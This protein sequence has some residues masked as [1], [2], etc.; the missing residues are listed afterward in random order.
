MRWGR[1]PPPRPALDGD[2]LLAE[3]VAADHVGGLAPN[4][5]QGDEF[6]DRAMEI[7]AEEMRRPPIWAK[8]LP[9]ASECDV[10]QNYGD[11]K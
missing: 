11:A 6:V 10:G 2:G 5:R 7:C 4:P 9:L 1:E 3:G 8:D